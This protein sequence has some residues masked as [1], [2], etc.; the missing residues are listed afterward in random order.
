MNYETNSIPSF[1]RVLIFTAA[2]DGKL[3]KEEL[4]NV[5]SSNTSLEER[6]EFV[7]GMMGAFSSILNDAFGIESD[8]EEEEEEEEV[9]LTE[10]SEDEIDDITKD[11]LSQLD[12]CSSAADLK[13]YSALICSRITDDTLKGWVC[14]DSFTICRADHIDT[15]VEDNEL[16][17]IKYIHKDLDEDFK[18]NHKEYL[19][20]LT[21][22]DDEYLVNDKGETDLKV[23]DGDID[24][25]ALLIT[26]A[27][28]AVAYSDWH[29]HVTNTQYVGTYFMALCDLARLNK[30]S[31]VAVTSDD[32]MYENIQE[33]LKE[34]E[35]HM[36]AELGREKIDSSIETSRSM[37]EKFNND[38]EA[39]EEAELI[40]AFEREWGESMNKYIKNLIKD[41]S[42]LNIQKTLYKVSYLLS[43]ADD[44][45]G[46]LNR[47]V[48]HE[49]N[50][51]S[52]DIG[53]GTVDEHSMEE[54]AA[55]GLIE[56]VF[57]FDEDT[58]YVLRNKLSSGEYRGL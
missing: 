15:L 17:N 37:W 34:I 45:G 41:I 38:E 35:G 52:D 33:S 4:N 19:H 2:G 39:E 43:Q 7:S 20:S 23:V 16:R 13:A 32:V 21:W 10:I 53:S 8:E 25:D 22:Y 9:N 55:L 18:E 44:D 27:A 36:I 56:E 58:S 26:K 11:V 49:M 48:V 51:F 50:I 3:S 6:Y 42:D 29:L 14:R 1:L 24:P 57:D 40:T 12:K 28:F 31:E 5:I 54:R 30:S 47:V 46:V